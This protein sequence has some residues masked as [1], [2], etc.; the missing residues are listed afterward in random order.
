M[1][2]RS[3]E[4]VM[5]GWWTENFGRAGKTLKGLSE[6]LKSDTQADRD[7]GAFAL[8]GMIA[9]MAERQKQEK[10]DGDR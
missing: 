4:A 1:K 3:D 7:A 10:T 8:R 5:A 9:R 2:A 6:Y